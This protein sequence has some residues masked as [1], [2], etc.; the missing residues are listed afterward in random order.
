MILNN[1]GDTLAAEGD[2]RAA[3]ACYEE[4]LAISRQ[5]GDTWGKG[6]ALLNLGQLALRAGIPCEQAN[7]STKAYR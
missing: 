6:I 4:G 5:R 1:L 7:C 2:L 3:Q